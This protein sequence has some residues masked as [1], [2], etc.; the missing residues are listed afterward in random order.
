MTWPSL[1]NGDFVRGVDDTERVFLLLLNRL[2]WEAGGDW[3]GGRDPAGW[4]GSDGPKSTA[5]GWGVFMGV[6]G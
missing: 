2:L 4:A 6:L 3:G 5:T 1:R